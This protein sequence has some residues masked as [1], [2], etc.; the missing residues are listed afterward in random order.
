[1]KTYTKIRRLANRSQLLLL[2]AALA[3]VLAWGSTAAAQPPAGR[4]SHGGHA[5]GPRG[6]GGDP[7]QMIERRVT[8]LT[9][10]LSLSEAQAGSIREILTEQSTRIEALRPT[11]RP[12]QRPDS[13][14][15]AQHRAQM[16]A[17]HEE[18]EARIEGVLTGEQ[19]ATYAELRAVRDGRGGPGRGMR[20]GR[21]GFRG[22]R[23]PPPSA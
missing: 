1:M 21:G 16:L 19:Q 10:V 13:A 12:A 11:E 5:M 6:R 20:G 2:V 3:G 15:L 9:E 17:I 7:A 14:T 8:R 23:P 4:G 22:R 18:T